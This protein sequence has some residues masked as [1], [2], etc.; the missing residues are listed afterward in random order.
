[1]RGT[2]NSEEMDEQWVCVLGLTE[3]FLAEVRPG[4]CVVNLK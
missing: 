3:L 2:N 4:S 1:M